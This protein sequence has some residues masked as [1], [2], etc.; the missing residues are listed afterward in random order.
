MA[1][2][3]HT[4]LFFENACSWDVEPLPFSTVDC[5]YCFPWCVIIVVCLRPTKKN[6][7]QKTPFCH[8]AQNSTVIEVGGPDFVTVFWPVRTRASWGEGRVRKDSQSRGEVISWRQF[9][10]GRRFEAL[11]PF[12]CLPLL[13]YWRVSGVKRKV[14]VSN[15]GPALPSKCSLFARGLSWVWTLFYALT[16]SLGGGFSSGSC[17][18]SCSCD[19]M[20]WRSSSLPPSVLVFRR[21]ESTYVMMSAIS[22]AAG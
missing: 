1:N 14:S 15:W 11:P 22:F 9:D 4:L 17:S 10:S 7:E 21:S 16:G 20:L 13:W 19:S 12:S 2:I 8:L 18:G 3:H 6:Q 5:R